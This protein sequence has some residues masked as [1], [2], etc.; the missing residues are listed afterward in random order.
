MPGLA[1]PSQR[2]LRGRVGPS[3]TMLASRFPPREA[4]RSPPLPVRSDPPARGTSAGSGRPYHGPRAACDRIFHERGSQP[5]V[6]I[7]HPGRRHAVAGG[8]EGPTEVDRAHHHHGISPARVGGQDEQVLGGLVADRETSDRPRATVDHDVAAEVVPALFLRAGTVVVVRVAQGEREMRYAVRVQVH[9]AVDPLGHLTVALPQLRTQL[10]AGS[11]NRIGT[12]EDGSVAG[13]VRDELQLALAL[14]AEQDEALWGIRDVRGR[15]VR[16]EAGSGCGSVLGDAIGDRRLAVRRGSMYPG[17]TS[18]EHREC[19]E[20]D[21]DP[22]R[23]GPATR[24]PHADGSYSCSLWL[25]PAEAGP[26]RPP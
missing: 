2:S 12:D 3:G 16:R 22:A 7:P 26:N 1:R 20:R 14:E 5:R 17:A 18:R 19:D 10:P 13:G 24:R 15:E 21:D 11:E 9:D 6:E 4:S 8:Q 25:D 23:P